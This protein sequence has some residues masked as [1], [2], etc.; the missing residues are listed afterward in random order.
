MD[1]DNN[2]YYGQFQNN[3][4]KGLTLLDSYTR[5]TRNQK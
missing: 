1:I 3:P 2:Q 4:Q 5:L